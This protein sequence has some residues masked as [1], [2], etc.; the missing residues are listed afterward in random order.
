[1]AAFCV[2]HNICEIHG[3]DFD[4]DWIEPGDQS[5]PN[6]PAAPADGNI[7]VGNEVRQ[8]LIQY[9]QKYPL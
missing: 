2:L 6:Q 8:T 9:F 1:M 4:E 5:D 3:D 7:P